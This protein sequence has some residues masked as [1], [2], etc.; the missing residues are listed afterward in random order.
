MSQKSK[1]GEPLTNSEIAAREKAMRDRQPKDNGQ[2]TQVSG[3]T[4]LR[5]SHSL[6]WSKDGAEIRDDARQSVVYS[7]TR[8]ECV[9]EAKRRGLWHGE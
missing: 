5:R 1:F 8:E 7:G 9:A 6:V 3:Q 2:R 4:S